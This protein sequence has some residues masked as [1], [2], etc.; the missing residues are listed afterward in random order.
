MRLK[1]PVVQ[2][3]GSETSETSSSANVGS[4]VGIASG[5]FIPVGLIPRPRP[6]IIFVPPIALP[7]EEQPQI[8]E[9]KVGSDDAIIA[10]YA[11]T[12]DQIYKSTAFVREYLRPKIEKKRIGDDYYRIWLKDCHARNSD[13]TQGIAHCSSLILMPNLKRQRCL[14][15]RLHGIDQ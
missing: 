15:I 10:E 2:P 3:A 8:L 5:A 1:K 9:I 4:A 11:P 14:L 13:G 6:P 7:G 12:Q